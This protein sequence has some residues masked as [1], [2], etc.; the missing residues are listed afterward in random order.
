ME[1]ILVVFAWTAIAVGVATYIDNRSTVVP[2]SKVTIEEYTERDPVLESE[3]DTS[4]LVDCDD[5][6]DPEAQEYHE[7]T[8]VVP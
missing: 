5:L 2:L 4:R 1:G 7:C 8:L 6:T 3:G